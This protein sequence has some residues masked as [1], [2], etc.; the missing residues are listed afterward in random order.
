[1]ASP[2]SRRKKCQIDSKPIKLSIY[3]DGK[4]TLL[5]YCVIQNA[6]STKFVDFVVA[7]ESRKK[8][9]IHKEF[10]F[11]GR[12]RSYCYCYEIHN[13]SARLPLMAFVRLPN[14]QNLFQ[15]SLY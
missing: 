3:G 15:N 2:K 12:L 9:R 1:M 4:Q 13:D 7:P 5:K 10:T 14:L 6:T 8:K 11:F